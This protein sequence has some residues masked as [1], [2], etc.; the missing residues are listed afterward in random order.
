MDA[1]QQKLIPILNKATGLIE[2]ID[3][4]S[5]NVVRIQKNKHTILEEKDLVKVTIDGKEI[6]A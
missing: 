2:I 5:G 1:S 6:W 3:P 4:I